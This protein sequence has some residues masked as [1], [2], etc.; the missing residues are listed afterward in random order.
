MVAVNRINIREQRTGD[1][2][3]GA[4]FFGAFFSAAKV[5]HRNCKSS[6]L[7]GNIFYCL[8]KSSVAAGREFLRVADYGKGKSRGFGNLKYQSHEKN[9]K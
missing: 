2:F 5:S 4:K 8:P 9:K 1:F 6:V 3:P 7:A